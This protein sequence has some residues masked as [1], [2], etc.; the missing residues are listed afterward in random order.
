[1]RRGFSVLWEVKVGIV[2]PEEVRGPR[3]VKYLIICVFGVGL[4]KNP[5]K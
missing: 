5:I 4:R 3:R 2:S 1:M